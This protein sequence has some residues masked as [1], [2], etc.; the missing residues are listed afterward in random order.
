MTDPSN[1]PFLEAI[2]RG[3]CPPELTPPNPDTPITI[4]MRR[5]HQPYEAPAQPRHVAFS[6]RGQKIAGSSPSIQTY[7]IYKH[8]FC[9]CSH[10]GGWNPNTQIHLPSLIPCNKVGCACPVIKICFQCLGESY[11]MCECLLATI[12]AISLRPKQQKLRQV[13]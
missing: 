12:Q 6:G 8:E 7:N 11:A 4:N 10:L 1:R 2:G 13:W 9:Y 5:S 3:E